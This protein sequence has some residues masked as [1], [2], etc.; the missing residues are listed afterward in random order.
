MTSLAEQLLF[1][2]N[3][4]R[5][6][7]HKRKLL[8]PKQFFAKAEKYNKGAIL[9]TRF[10]LTTNSYLNKIRN[11]FWNRK[12]LKNANIVFKKLWT[13]YENKKIYEIPDFFQQRTN[14][15]NKKIFEFVNKFGKGEHFLWISQCFLK[16]WADFENANFFWKFMNILWNI[17][18][19]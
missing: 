17:N 2:K 11:A 9:K 19:F 14:Y 1:K 12:N 10:F 3:L 4:M 6:S 7:A 16:F 15:E 8:F 18:I 5:F 13:N